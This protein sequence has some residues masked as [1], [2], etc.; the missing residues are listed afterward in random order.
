M[1]EKIVQL[2]EEI[3]KGQLKELIR[4]SVGTSDMKKLRKQL[5][6]LLL[7]LNLCLSLCISAAGASDGQAFTDV[8]PNAWYYTFSQYHF[9]S[10]SPRQPSCRSVP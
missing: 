9:L 4:R 8:S 5:L 1:S 10:M 2:N 7:A 3:I 6:S